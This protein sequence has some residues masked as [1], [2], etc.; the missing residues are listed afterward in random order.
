MSS[1]DLNNEDYSSNHRKR[2]PS[3]DALF[4]AQAQQFFRNLERQSGHH[5]FSQDDYQS[6]IFVPETSIRGPDQLAVFQGAS[7]TPISE[8]YGSSP[9]AAGSVT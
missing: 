9:A 2:L 7:E 4:R 1:S 8:S 5:H 3:I 6:G